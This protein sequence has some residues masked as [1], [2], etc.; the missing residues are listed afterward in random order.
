MDGLR[1]TPDTIDAMLKRRG[2]GERVTV[3]AF[4]RD[5]LLTVD[6]ELAEPPLDTC[7]L[8]LREAPGERAQALR[9]GWLRSA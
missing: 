6:V 5:E 3:H 4:R 9:D 8:T 1:A 2:P 7:Y